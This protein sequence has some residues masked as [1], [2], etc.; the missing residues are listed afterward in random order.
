[1]L[2]R[3]RM[4]LLPNRRIV[5][6]FSPPMNQVVFTSLINDNAES[7][8]K[9]ENEELRFRS[10]SFQ[11]QKLDRY[12]F[13]HTSI[14]AKVRAK[15]MPGYSEE[16]TVCLSIYSRGRMFVYF[17]LFCWIVISLGGLVILLS[18]KEILLSI[19]FVLLFSLVMVVII[20]MAR[21]GFEDRGIRCFMYRLETEM[22]QK[23]LKN[24]D[25]FEA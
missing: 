2:A 1:M 15:L 11:G 10:W 20:R 6:R 12:A 9:L 23:G 24:L 22:K 7:I 25:Y 21:E 18:S 8:F 19:G 3:L 16:N 13:M 4:F 17:F 5:L 14:R